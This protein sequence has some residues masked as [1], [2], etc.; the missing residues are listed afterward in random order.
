MRG[1]ADGTPALAAPLPDTVSG[2][3]VVL[4]PATGCVTPAAVNALCSWL[5]KAVPASA[6]VMLAPSAA[7][8]VADV[9]PTA[10]LTPR[11]PDAAA[12]T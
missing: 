4:T 1:A 6:V 11:P 5:R 7:A 12:S 3:T 8:A 2:T 10:K 9:A